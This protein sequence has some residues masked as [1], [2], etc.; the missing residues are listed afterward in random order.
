[1]RLVKSPNIERILNLDVPLLTTSNLYMAIMLKN[2]F[3]LL[4]LVSFIIHLQI[5]SIFALLN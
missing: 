1:M 5:F 3:S 2:S 4:A